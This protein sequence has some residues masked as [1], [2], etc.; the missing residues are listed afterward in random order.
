VSEDYYIP[1]SWFIQQ[2]VEGGV[3]GFGLFVFIF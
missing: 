1:E 3:I 2:A